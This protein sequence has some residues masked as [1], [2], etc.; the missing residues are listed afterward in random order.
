MRKYF[1]LMVVLGSSLTG[2]ATVDPNALYVTVASVPAG[3]MLYQENPSG[4]EPKSLGMAGRTI[5]YRIT[6]ANRTTRKLVG[7]PITA[8][9]ASGATKTQKLSY[10]FSFGNKITWTFQRPTDAPGLGEDMRFALELEKNARAAK[11]AAD[12]QNARLI[13]AFGKGLDQGWQRNHQYNIPDTPYKPM[14]RTTCE[15][16][17]GRVECTTW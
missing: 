17:F 1:L 11:A 9:W 15:E 13:E 7:L 5:T 6:E 12:E 8:R 14:L 4:G 10:D 3:A 16:R 2:C